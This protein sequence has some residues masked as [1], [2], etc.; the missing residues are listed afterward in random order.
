MQTEA[1]IDEAREG[2]RPV[3]TRAAL[4]FFVLNDLGSVDPMY[5]FSLDA[6]IVQFKMSMKDSVDASKAGDVAVHRCNVHV[7]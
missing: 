7:Q 2:Y 5:Q 6:Y 3:A 1:Q 4:L